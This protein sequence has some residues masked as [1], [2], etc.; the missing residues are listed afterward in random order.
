MWL[1]TALVA[2]GGVK[3]SVVSVVILA[4]GI[5]SSF[6]REFDHHRHSNVT[7]DPA[8]KAAMTANMCVLSM[9]DLER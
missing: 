2:L 1:L 5:A 6:S 3:A 9:I 4:A 7:I 8:V